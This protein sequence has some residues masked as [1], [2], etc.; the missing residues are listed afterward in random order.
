MKRRVVITGLGAI[1]PIGNDAESFWQGLKEKKL[2]F[3]PITHFDTTESVSYTHLDVYK[4]QVLNSKL[5][6]V[7]DYVTT[8]DGLK[9]EVHS[10]NVLRQLVKVVVTVNDEKEI[11]EYKVDDLRFK[12]R[13]KKE[14]GKI[15]KLEDAELKQL[16]D[17]EKKEGKPRQNGNKPEGKRAH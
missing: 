8:A 17:L 12:P 4:R 2:G 14:K 15:D 16:E 6:G 13:K 9:G 3:G 5:P 11:R 1:T 7:G 10:V